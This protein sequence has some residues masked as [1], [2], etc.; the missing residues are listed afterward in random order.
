MTSLIDKTYHKVVHGH[1]VSTPWTGM[2]MITLPFFVSDMEDETLFDDVTEKKFFQNTHHDL[3]DEYMNINNVDLTVFPTP[4]Q[5]YIGQFANITMGP[6]YRNGVAVLQDSLTENEKFIAL[7]TMTSKMTMPLLWDN[8][9]KWKHIYNQNAVHGFGGLHNLALYLF[10]ALYS[11]FVLWKRNEKTY[12]VLGLISGM[13]IA[14]VLIV[15]I[16]MHAVI[17]FTFHNDS[18]IFLPIFVILTSLNKKRYES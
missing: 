1:F 10:I 6:I 7:D 3:V 12:K 5:F 2:N 18:I 8:F 16:G 14:N 13:L 9:S 15:S 11:F 4:T 17:R